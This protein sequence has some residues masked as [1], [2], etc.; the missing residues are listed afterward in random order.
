M[1]IVIHRRVVTVTVVIK[2]HAVARLLQVVNVCL[3]VRWPQPPGV[4]R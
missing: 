4:S 1:A 3:S 2:E